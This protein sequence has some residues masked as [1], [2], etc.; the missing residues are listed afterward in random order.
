MLKSCI[1]FANGGN[2]DEREVEWYRGQMKEIDESIEA[3][4]AQR[5]EKMKEIAEEMARLMKEPNENFEKDYQG[6]IQ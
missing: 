5:D 3:I 6:S 4:K 2:Y 1:L